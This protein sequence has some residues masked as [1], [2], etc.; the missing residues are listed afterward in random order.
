[1]RVRFDYRGEKTNRFIFGG[2]SPDRLAEDAREHRAALLRNIPI[3]G[4]TIEDINMDVDVYVVYEEETGREVA[5]APLELT[6]RADMLEDVVRFI[7]CQEFRKI[8]ILEPDQL[9]LTSN[10]IERILYKM[11][12]ELNEFGELLVRKLGNR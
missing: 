5:Y 6:I 4:I 11:S 3:Q 8:E 7:S 2:K 10:E 12:Q 1:M 9:H